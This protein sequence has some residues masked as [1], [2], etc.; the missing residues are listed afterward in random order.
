MDVESIMR[1]GRRLG[2][3]RTDLDPSPHAS[4]N[5]WTGISWPVVRE[6]PWPPVVF[7]PAVDFRGLIE[8]RRSRRVL[9]KI[10]FRET[11]NLISF[12]IAPRFEN[13]EGRLRSL[14]LSAGALHAVDL[15]LMRGGRLFR[16][17]R[18][19]RL[20]Q[21]LGPLDRPK[22]ARFSDRTRELLP[23]A[24]SS[25]VIFVGDLALIGAFYANPGSLLFRDAGALLQTLA[26]AAEAY[27]LGFCPLGLLGREVVEALG[28]ES[29]AAVPLGAAALGRQLPAD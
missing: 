4:P 3:I 18:R 11:I 29:T 17:D 27:G 19:C 24:D 12:A 28:L 21:A 1:L 26:L 5:P 13:G 25:T 6:W 14:S 20:L 15:V 16:L 22:L 7:P 2:L 10:S 9:S 23:G 8:S